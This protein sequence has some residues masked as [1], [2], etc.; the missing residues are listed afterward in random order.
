MRRGKFL[1]SHL[2]FLMK[3]NGIKNVTELSLRS[4]IKQSTLEKLLDCSFQKLDINTVNQLVDFFECKPDSLLSIEDEYTDYSWH[5]EN[6]GRNGVVYFL[7]RE[8]N[9]LTKIGWTANIQQ[10]KSAI[11]Q[12]E[13]VKTRLIHYIPTFDCI[14]L[15][16]TL[17]IIFSKKRVESEWFNLTEGDLDTLKTDY[18]VEKLFPEH[19]K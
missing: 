2:P 3:Q 15:E 12:K 7:Q 13:K 11:E 9:G 14:T 6:N 8:D 4:G 5:I 16:S 10:R 19:E 18:Y 1:V 17:H